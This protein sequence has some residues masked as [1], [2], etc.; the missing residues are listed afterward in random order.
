M[1]VVVVGLDSA[2]NAFHLGGPQKRE[3]DDLLTSTDTSISSQEVVPPSS[4]TDSDASQVVV[5]PFLTV[6]APQIDFSPSSTDQTV[7]DGNNLLSSN[8]DCRDGKN[9]DDRKKPEYLIEYENARDEK[10]YHYRYVLYIKHPIYLGV[11][12]LIFLGT[13]RAKIPRYPKMANW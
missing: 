12:N 7:S 2:V 5:P 6:I 11:L 8:D 10:G 1:L 3:Q 9:C 4:L 13:K